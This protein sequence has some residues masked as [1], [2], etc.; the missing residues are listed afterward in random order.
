MAAQLQEK[1][2]NPELFV[3]HKVGF[4]QCFICRSAVNLFDTKFSHQG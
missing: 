4:I 2:Q 1:Y 3:N